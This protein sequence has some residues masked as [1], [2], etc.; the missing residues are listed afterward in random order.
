MKGNTGT[1]LVNPVAPFG[2][3]HEFFILS[4]TSNYVLQIPSSRCLFNIYSVSIIS[5]SLKTLFWYWFESRKSKQILLVQYRIPYSITL[6]RELK[7]WTCAFRKPIKKRPLANR[8]RPLTNT[9]KMQ[10]I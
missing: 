6:R 9:H 10:R 8:N 5:G 1:L 7:Q 3:F 2:S 4:P